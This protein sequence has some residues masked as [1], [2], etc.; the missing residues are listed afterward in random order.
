M[1]NADVFKVTLKEACELVNYKTA[2]LY[3]E[4]GYVIR[5]QEN[6]ILRWFYPGSNSQLFPKP[7]FINSSQ[8][9]NEIVKRFKSEEQYLV[10][11]YMSTMPK[12]GFVFICFSNIQYVFLK[13]HPRLHQ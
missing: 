13:P 1:L 4:L 3:V 6:E 9:L 5:H 11:R 12:S 7:F 2:F 10:T 8:Y